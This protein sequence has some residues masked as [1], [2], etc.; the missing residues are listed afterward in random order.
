MIFLNRYLD[1]FYRL[2]SSDDAV[3]FRALLE[4]KDWL[5]RKLFVPIRFDRTIRD[6]VTLY[7]EIHALM[8]SAF[9]FK[10]LDYDRN[11]FFGI[12]YE[13]ARELIDAFNSEYR[14]LYLKDYPDFTEE[15]F[16]AEMDMRRIDERT[17]RDLVG[18]FYP[19]FQNREEADL[20]FES[21][22]SELLKLAMIRKNGYVLILSKESLLD[23]RYYLPAVCR[24]HCSGRIGE[25]KKRTVE[26]IALGLRAEVNIYD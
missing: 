16:F 14:F 13:K 7:P 24:L 17:Y 10:K 6:G 26:E 2:F 1:N 11:L 5:F 25:E 3:S 19:C 18:N 23:D 20:S 4:K 9:V 21:K 8:D 22:P 12:E 15:E